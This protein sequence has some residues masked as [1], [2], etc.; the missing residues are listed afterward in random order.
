MLGVIEEVRTRQYR[1]KN[2]E[3]NWCELR[4]TRYRTSDNRI[5]GVVLSVMGAEESADQGSPGRP[6]KIK[7]PVSTKK[8][9]KK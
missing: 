6:R 9:T 4:L 1:V 5:D 8:K 7:R 3:G 2:E